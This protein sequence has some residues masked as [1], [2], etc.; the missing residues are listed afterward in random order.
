VP[1]P[2]P[3]H[4][5]L[6]RRALPALTLA[7]AGGLLLVELDHPSSPQA[8]AA[9]PAFGTRSAATGA[10]APTSPAGGA[11]SEIP[12][13]VP[14]TI[15]STV[16]A[17]P[18]ACSKDETGPTVQTRWGPVQV[19]AIVSA[20]GK[21][22][23]VQALQSPTGARRSIAINA[24]ALPILHDRAVQSGTA[25]DAVSGATITSEGYRSSLQAIVDGG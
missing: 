4:A 7:G 18:Q 15:P 8:P 16:P 5:S 17:A 13:T 12:A 25:F 11:Q 24:E 23:D 22:C 3:R 10:T 14:G 19:E 21:V 2:S 6:A 20:D 9:A 1:V